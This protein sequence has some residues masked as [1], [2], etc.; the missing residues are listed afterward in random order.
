MEN[1]SREEV[2]DQLRQHLLQQG[3]ALQEINAVI[4]VANREVFL[5]HQD[6][7][8]RV[9][10]VLKNQEH[11]RM[12]RNSSKPYKIGGKFECIDANGHNH[13]AYIDKISRPTGEEDGWDEFVDAVKESDVFEGGSFKTEETNEEAGTTHIFTYFHQTYKGRN[14]VNLVQG[15]F[16]KIFKQGKYN[17]SL[18]PIR[19]GIVNLYRLEILDQGK[20][21]GTEIITELNRISCELDVEI[22]LEQGDVGL[23]GKSQGGTDKDNRSN[24]YIKNNFKKIKGIQWYSNKELI[25]T[26]YENQN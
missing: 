14:M 23:L 10:E 17:I 1:I 24:F 7:V 25:D 13:Y 9:A 26:Y 8:D 20:G 4:N 15:A 22:R 6:F 11:K 19:D 16:L 2:T 21:I 12:N 18:F 5:D 3:M